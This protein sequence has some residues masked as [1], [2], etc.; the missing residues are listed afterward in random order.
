MRALGLSSSASTGKDLESNPPHPT[1]KDLETQGFGGLYAVG[2]AAEKPPALVTLA[3]D[4]GDEEVVSMVGKGI[5]Y[6]TGGLSIKGKEFMPTMKRDM[7][8]AAAVLGAFQAAVKI[9]TKK[10]LRA[11]LCLAEN[12][13]SH[14]AY[15][16]D[17]I[18][19]MRSGKTVEVNNTDAEGRMVLGDG[20]HYAA[21]ELKS[22]IVVDICTLT[23]A[24]KIAAGNK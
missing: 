1:G 21:S 18:I 20:V 17:D 2:K 16:N 24:Q 19:H 13:I 22:A 15:R 23:G 3:Y 12:A 9:G 7:G 5:V 4:G 14:L 6:D 10:K 8:G 11:V